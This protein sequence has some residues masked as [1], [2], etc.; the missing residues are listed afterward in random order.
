LFNI[1]NY[2]R[3]FEKKI[4]HL[5]L[6]FRPGEGDEEIVFL[7]LMELLEG[8]KVRFCPTTLMYHPDSDPPV[9]LG[10]SRRVDLPGWRLQDLLPRLS[11][12]GFQVVET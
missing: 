9:E 6:N 5:P 3:I 1:L 10:R 2:E 8:G 4:R 11:K 7:R 12:A